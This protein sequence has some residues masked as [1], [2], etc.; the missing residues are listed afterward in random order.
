MFVGYWQSPNTGRFKALLSNLLEGELVR[1]V[2]IPIPLPDRAHPLRI[3]Q[4]YP[5]RSRYRTTASIPLKKFG[6]WNF[7]FGEW[8]LSSGSPNPINTLG[9]PM[10][11]AN[12]PTMGIDPPDRI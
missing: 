10:F 5:N 4:F 6:R 3:D 8:R 12:V 7:S 2:S 11:S 1:P 9:M